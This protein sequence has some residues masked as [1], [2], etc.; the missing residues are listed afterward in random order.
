MA[1]NL[2]GSTGTFN[3]PDFRKQFLDE[4]QP[5]DTFD[6]TKQPLFQEITKATEGQLAGATPGFDIQAA[7][8]RD[9]F[10]AAEA[11]RQKS[12]REQLMG[13]GLR[14]SGTYIQEG[15]VNPAQEQ[16]RRRMQLERQLTADRGQQSQQAIQAGIQGG[17]NLLGMQQQGELGFAGL[18]VE[19]QRLAQEGS[20]FQSR[21]DFDKWATQ[22]GLDENSRQRIWQSIENAKGREST[23]K[24]AFAGLS[25]DEKRLAQEAMQFS[26]RLDFDKWATE[27][28][29]AENEKQRIWEATENEKQRQLTERMSTAQLASQENIAFAQIDAEKWK[30]GRI[31]AL[32]KEGWS[33]EAAQ[34]EADRQHA[35]TINSINNALQKEI[36]SGRITLEES[37]L[38][39][40]ATQFSSQ[41]EFERWAIDQNIALENARRT[42]QIAD[43]AQAEAMERLRIDAEMKMLGSQLAGNEKIAIMNQELQLK[44]QS[45]EITMQEKELAQQAFQFASAQDFEK[46]AMGQNISLEN[47]RRSWQIADEQFMAQHEKEMADLGQ[48]FAEKNISLTAVL[49]RLSTMEPEQAADTFKQIAEENGITLPD[50]PDKPAGFETTGTAD[51][52]KYSYD[53]Q[54]TLGGNDVSVNPGTGW[55]PLSAGQYVRFDQNANAP[56]LGYGQLPAGTYKVASSD[57]PAMKEFLGQHP[58]LSEYVTNW[59]VD[60]SSGKAYPASV[61]GRDPNSGSTV[62]SFGQS[63][64]ERKSKVA[65][66]MKEYY[67]DGI[68]I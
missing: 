1:T 41:Q 63:Y 23:E 32:T 57:D 27:A 66:I 8:A 13:A 51:A 19:E 28:G 34:N 44:L 60:E 21:L 48:Q 6:I 18:S 54:V 56:E 33:F 14:D 30:Q 52:P 40:Q 12:M 11:T 20:Q 61:S 9:A 31:E 39:Q 15:I 17:T 65:D 29:L 4:Q 26:D 53:T 67:K 16:L 22:A 5:K 10:K 38:A 25:L 49:D 47:A 64:D 36:E 50:T 58:Q 45:G 55:E 37:R 7:E 68:P 62:F 42:W 24:I 2:F 43:M 35:M 3:T 59:W 46:W